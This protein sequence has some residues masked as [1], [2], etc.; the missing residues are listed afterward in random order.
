MFSSNTTIILGAGASYDFGAP[1]GEELW[2]RVIQNS[3]SLVAVY[4]Q[5]WDRPVVGGVERF[6][7]SQKTPNPKAF[8]YF[9]TLKGMEGDVHASATSVAETIRRANFHTSVDDFLRDNPSLRDPVRTLI[10]AVLFEG[11]YEQHERSWQLRRGCFEPSFQSPWRAGT[12]ENWIRLFVGVCRPLVL[13]AQTL[14]PVQVIS[15][16]YDRLLQTLLQQM[17][18][19]AERDYPPLDQCFQFHY[20]YGA[21]SELPTELHDSSTWILQ[22]FENLGLADGTGSSVV[23][24]VRAAID[25]ADQVFSVGFSWTETNLQLLGISAG[26]EKFHVQNFGGQDARLARTL[27]RLGIFKTDAGSMSDLVRNGFFEQRTGL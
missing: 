23:D 6:L 12:V 3:S 5:F 4:E 20:P 21:F 27:S 16:N 2:R 13:K 9:S 8:A 15:F 24:E 10:A 22:Q 19:V 25:E 7:Q 18:P 17:W 14:T 26:G 11:L 1:L